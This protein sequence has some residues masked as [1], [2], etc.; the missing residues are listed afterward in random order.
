MKPIHY[1]MIILGIF[2]LGIIFRL[3]WAIRMTD[4]GTF[5]GY[6]KGKLIAFMRVYTNLF[7]VAGVSVIIMIK[8]LGLIS[9][10][11]FVAL[12]IAGFSALGINISN[13][14]KTIEKLPP[15]SQQEQPKT[16]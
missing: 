7:I 8:Q 11:L 12:L 10:D 5:G 2:L 6:N 16:D 15:D 1:E 13:S 3:S 4:F 9:Q 14:T